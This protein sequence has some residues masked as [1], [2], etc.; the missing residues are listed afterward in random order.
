MVDDGAPQTLTDDDLSLAIEGLRAWHARFERDFPGDST[1]RQPVHTVYGGAHLFKAGSARRIGDLALQ[2]LD[3]YAREAAAFTA[4]LG[5]ALPDD[6][7]ADLRA[8]VVDKLTREPVEDFRIDFED[9]Y[10]H[11]GDAEEDAHCAS[12]AA[13][14]ATGFRNGSL[15]PFIGIRIKPL[16]SELHR[17][18]LRTL[19]L[20]TTALGRGLDGSFVPA[21]R[22]TLPKVVDASEVA[23]ASLACEALERRL[24]LDSGVLR[25]ELMVETPQ[26][27]FTADGR[28][29]LR[30]FVS[31]GAGRVVAAHFGAYDYTA[32]CGI[33]A[34]WQDLR[35]PACDF[36]RHM[37]QAALA[38]SGVQLSDS[39]TA[40]LPVPVHRPGTATLTSE[41]RRENTSNVHR[42]WRLHFDN[43]R[44]SLRHGFYQSWD[45]HPAQL[46][47]RYAAVYDFF[48]TARGAAAQ[49]LRHFVEQATHATLAGGVF[50]DEA[51]AQGLV[52]FFVRGVNCGALTPPEVEETGLTLDE[53]RGRSFA[54]IIDQRRRR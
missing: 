20:F 33:T 34:S 10:G 43:V 40:I 9:G 26:A 21:L 29:P 37:M 5:L 3:D 18:G 13:E 41:Q 6:A 19:D 52:N 47:P 11:R 23:V 14:V 42:A 22:I 17:R 54:K 7:A 28:S 36:A 2:A 50:D 16:S 1:E 48:N 53:L 32:L 45:L 38:Q 27:L 49:R 46:I 24:G 51:T 4:A 8:R 31:A 25:L 30:D 35:H 44:H 15:P 12:A 39:V